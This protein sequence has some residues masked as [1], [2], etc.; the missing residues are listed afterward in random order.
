[1]LRLSVKSR[2]KLIFARFGKCENACLHP[3]IWSVLKP[4]NFKRKQVRTWKWQLLEAT[5]KASDADHTQSCDLW[6]MPLLNWYFKTRICALKKSHNFPE[7]AATWN[8]SGLVSVLEA[9]H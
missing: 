2:E 8:F 7:E 1:M 4:R 9:L 6:L 5:L 3:E